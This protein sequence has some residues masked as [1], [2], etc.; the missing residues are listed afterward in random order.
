[1]YLIYNTLTKDY[2]QADYRQDAEEQ[3]I[4]TKEWLEEQR[5]WG[6]SVYVFESKKSIVIKED[7]S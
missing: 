2:D 5:A 6:H 3:F 7:V 1:M 4:A